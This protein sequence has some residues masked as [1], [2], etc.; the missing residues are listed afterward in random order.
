M[1]RVSVM[2]SSNCSLDC[3]FVAGSPSADLGSGAGFQPSDCHVPGF[4]TTFHQRDD[5][6]RGASSSKYTE[7]LYEIRDFHC[8]DGLH[9]AER[10]GPEPGV[11]T[12]PNSIHGSWRK[13]RQAWVTASLRKVA[14]EF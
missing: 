7:K 8:S 6:A 2:R 14:L 13:E 9:T 10:D 3:L 12:Q 11:K 5:A 4:P 1:R